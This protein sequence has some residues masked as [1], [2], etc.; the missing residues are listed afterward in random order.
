MIKKLRI[1]MSKS[2]KKMRDSVLRAILNYMPLL[3]QT[4]LFRLSSRFFGDPD[5]TWYLGRIY[6]KRGDLRS[7]IAAYE[8]AFQMADRRENAPFPPRRQAYQFS[9]E[10]ARRNAGLSHQADPLLAC[11]VKLP[12]G[13]KGVAGPGSF[14]ATFKY[15]GL[16]VIVKLA[17]DSFQYFDLLIDGTPFRRV[18]ILAD[19]YH[20]K[21]TVKRPGLLHFPARGRLQVRTSDHSYLLSKGS[22]EL[23][24]EIP[25]GR[26][27]IGDILEDGIFLE[28]KGELPATLRE[29]ARRQNSYLKLYAK[30]REFFREE[31][32]L[33]LFLMYG[34][35][36]GLYRDGDFIPGDDDF[37]VGYFS[38]EQDP[39]AVKEEVMALIVK[40]VQG[41]FT[42]GFNQAGRPFRL[43]GLTD[44]PLTH[45]DV[46]P[47]WFQEGMIWAHDRTCPSCTEQDFLPV[48]KALFR[49]TEVYIPQHP[50]RFLEAYYGPGWKTPD[51]S[52]T[53]DLFVDPRVTKNLA[54]LCLT[55]A[56]YRKLKQR[57]G[58]SGGG[59]AGGE[60]IFKSAVDLYPLEEYT[61]KC[62]WS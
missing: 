44:D 49:G 24:L 46:R 35:L 4:W 47:L 51:P 26:G 52:Y 13:T 32:N 57:A 41:G 6:E 54:R 60:I 25:H 9:L 62:G 33:E 48:R 29:L 1:R 8:K 59:R 5:F 30:A 45:L 11:R 21:F 16:L 43:R 3:F 37:D 12:P 42:V 20:Y 34:T 58:G 27:D 18:K 28:K 17:D 2:L 56:D 38:Q 31:L 50:D 55:L 19:T 15:N 39:L 22:P 61:R 53:T 36:L 14:K 23:I 7:A 40:L 10:R